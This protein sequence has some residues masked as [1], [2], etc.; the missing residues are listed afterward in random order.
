MRPQVCALVEV[1]KDEGNRVGQLRPQR[2]G[3]KI[4]K[5]ESARIRPRRRSRATGSSRDLC[6]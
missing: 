2:I 6:A 4:C 3:D 1:G 5:A